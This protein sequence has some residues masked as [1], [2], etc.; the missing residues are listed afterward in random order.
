M[1]SVLHFTGV[2]SHTSFKDFIEIGV[3]LCFCTL[4]NHGLKM[5]FSLSAIVQ[6][7]PSPP[8]GFSILKAGLS[9]SVLLSVYA[10]SCSSDSQSVNSSRGMPLSSKEC[11]Y[12]HVSPPPNPTRACYLHV[13]INSV[14]SF[15]TFFSFSYQRSL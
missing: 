9:K 4:Q 5:L 8:L 6:R 12:E 3:L 11:Y 13:M 10:S 14:I 15:L 7:T 2:P 1:L